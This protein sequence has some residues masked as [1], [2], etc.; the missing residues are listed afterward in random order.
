MRIT[1][2]G[3]SGSI[4]SDIFQIAKDVGQEIA[5]RKGLLITGG[6]DGVMEAASKGAKEEQGTTIGILA[7]D[8]AIAANPYVD[9]AIATG[10]GY[11]R[12]YLNIISS[13]AVIS[14]AGS[15]GTL[16]EIGFAIALQKKLI[17][18]KGTGGVTDMIIQNRM[19]FPNADIYLA[20]T[21]KEAVSL[22]FS[23]HISH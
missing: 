2:I 9:I 8:K 17:L 10:I 3:S 4:S 13:D 11:A 18:I 23:E 21:Y 15:G 5:K 12:N 16:S 19:L 7:E 1:V 22:A 20:K 14:I 6:K